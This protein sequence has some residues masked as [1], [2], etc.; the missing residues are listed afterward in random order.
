MRRARRDHW[1]G[2]RRGRGHRDVGQRYEGLRRRANT[3]QARVH[4]SPCHHCP[5]F[6][7][8]R[9]HRREIEDKESTL[10]HGEGELE[11]ARGRFRR[12]FH[13]FRSVLRA[14]GF[15]DGDRLT[16]LGL[17]AA[18]LY[19]ESALLVADAIASG[20]LEGLRPEELAAALVMLV[21]EDRGRG[22]AP[23]GRRHFPTAQVDLEHRRLRQA[24]QRFTAVEREHGLDTIPPL[25]YD[26][27][28]P[29]Y[30]WA[31]GR[32]LSD[33]EPPGGADLGDVVK[34]VKNLYSLL[35][36]MEQALR[37]HPLRA[38]VAATRE[39]VERDLIRRV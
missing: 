28:R 38:L 23:A 20:R 33:I 21:A 18:S 1:H 19:G 13:A 12:E 25:S 35:R 11:F 24:Q 7:E 2:G 15:L 39:S 30:E 5:Y 16:D 3:V 17:L 34:A 26:F 10:R 37:A 9:A 6:A 14:T 31:S 36:Q 22:P 8:H 4:E 32:D 27:V 29:T